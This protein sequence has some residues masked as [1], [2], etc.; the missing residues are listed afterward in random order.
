MLLFSNH[1]HGYDDFLLVIEAKFKSGKSGINENDQLARYFEAIYKDIE[2]FS[3][4]C[5]SNFKGKKGYID[6][7]PVQ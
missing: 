6:L 4:T 3:N 1:V 7:T 5:I 2:N